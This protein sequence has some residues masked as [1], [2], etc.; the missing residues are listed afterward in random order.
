MTSISDFQT[1][2]LAG[3]TSSGSTSLNDLLINNF[4]MVNIGGVKETN[5]LFLRSLGSDVRKAMDTSS[6]ILK[7]SDYF[8]AATLGKFRVDASPL[9]M[10]FP[11][12]VLESINEIWP[13]ADFRP[14]VL[15]IV[16]NPLKRAASSLLMLRNLYGFQSRSFK[17]LRDW[18]LSQGSKEIF[19]CSLHPRLPNYVFDVVGHSIFWDKIDMYAKALGRENVLVITLDQLVADPTVVTQCLLKF[20]G[21][22]S[23][24]KAYLKS[25]IDEITLKHYGKKESLNW[26]SNYILNVRKPKVFHD[27]INF[28]GIKGQVRLAK[29]MLLD[30]SSVMI[31]G[32]SSYSKLP[33]EDIG[34][35]MDQFDGWQ[36]DLMSYHLPWLLNSSL[37]SPSSLEL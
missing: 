17:E 11:E 31:T 14:K 15:F 21:S 1:I 36:Q 10:Y 33:Q 37:P 20:I 19:K 24:T 3:A 9:Y 4:S 32:K 25:G 22:T 26:A 29:R 13:C 34:G 27:I 7:E 28:I 12:I 23:L 30:I 16:R 18:W 35:I 8:D 6:S 2:L 5:F